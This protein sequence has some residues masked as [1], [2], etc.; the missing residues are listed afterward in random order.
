MQT[1]MNKQA[2]GRIRTSTLSF[3]KYGTLSLCDSSY[4]KI[5]DL[6]FVEGSIWPR[7][8]ADGNGWMFRLRM[9][10]AR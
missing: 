7:M 5:R 8:T 6:R 4:R 2:D 3:T 9:V 10:C 1:L